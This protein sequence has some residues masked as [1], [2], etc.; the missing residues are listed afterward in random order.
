MNETDKRAMPSNSHDIEAK[1]NKVHYTQQQREFKFN[2]NYRDAILS[3]Y[4][5]RNKT[6][7]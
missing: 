1:I 2:F 5:K 7:E 6:D 3:D 4:M